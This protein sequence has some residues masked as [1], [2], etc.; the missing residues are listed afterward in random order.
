MII[1]QIGLFL[2]F[3]HTCVS[4]HNENTVKTFEEY[5]E[6]TRFGSNHISIHHSRSSY[7]RTNLTNGPRIQNYKKP[8][9]YGEY[10]YI[11]VKIYVRDRRV[12]KLINILCCRSRTTAR[13]ISCPTPKSGFLLKYFSLEFFSGLPVSSET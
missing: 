5:E 8:E 3:L 13:T 7:R 12:W 4:V 10:Y 11:G 1:I 9:K 6:M 2:L